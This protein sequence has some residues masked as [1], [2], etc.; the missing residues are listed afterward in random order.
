[1]YQESSHIFSNYIFKVC[2]SIF[3]WSRDFLCITV[4]LMVRTTDLI[5]CICCPSIFCYQL[6]P[7]VLLSYIKIE[8]INHLHPCLLVYQP[9]IDLICFGLTRAVVPLH[10]RPKL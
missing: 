6:S 10:T 4:V 8:C 1:M 5:N 2:M 3:S 7:S 9:K